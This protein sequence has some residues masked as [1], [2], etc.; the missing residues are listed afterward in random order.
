MN[1]TK[2]FI[3]YVGGKSKLLNYIINNMPIEFNNYFEPFVGGGSVIFGLISNGVVIN[4]ICTIS[5]INDNLINCYNV[6]KNNL[7]DLKKELLELKYENKSDNYYLCRE[8]FNKIKFNKVEDEFVE[9]AALFIFLNKCGFNGM[10]RENLSGK[11]NIPFGN[12]KNPKICD[13]EVLDNINRL[14]SDKN[15]IINS[16][17]YE[18]ILINIKENDFVYIDSPY[19]ETFTGYTS[20]KFGKNEQSKLKLF[21]DILTKKKVKVM[22]SNSSTIFIKELYKDYNQ[23]NLTTKYSLGGKNTNRS[24]DKCELLITNYN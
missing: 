9:K 23:V 10:Y 13:T 17:E 7:D 16:C 3:K 2:S 6:I 14:L 5:D 19:D 15:I 21:V 1:K 12:M 22:L 24:E 8:R 20:S 4:K 11:F 18:N